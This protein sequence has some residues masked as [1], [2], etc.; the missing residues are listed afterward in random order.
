MFPHVFSN[1]LTIIA[2]QAITFWNRSRKTKCPIPG[3]HKNFNYLM[4][5]LFFFVQHNF[6]IHLGL[7]IVYCFYIVQYFHFR[8]L[9]LF[10]LSSFA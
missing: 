9:P 10:Y 4:Y 7:S 1:F 2:L 5:A 3:H 6:V 8:I